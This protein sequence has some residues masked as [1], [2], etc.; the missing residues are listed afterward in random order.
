MNENK[1]PWVELTIEDFTDILNLASEGRPLE[2]LELFQAVEAK[3]KEKN[4]VAQ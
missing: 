1:T 3:V 4:Y 2:I